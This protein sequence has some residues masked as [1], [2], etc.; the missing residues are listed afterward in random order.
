[1]NDFETRINALDL[2]LFQYVLSQSTEGDRRSLLAIQRVLR[3]GRRGSGYV[4]LEIGSFMGG[5]L[6]P[7]VADPLCRKIISID[8]RPN[9]YPDIRGKPGK[10]QITA[11][12]ML[13]ELARV[14]GA[15]V[16]KITTFEA[17]TDTLDPLSI[18]PRPDYCF[19]DGEHTDE[20]VLRDSLFCQSV[21]QGNGWILYHDAN[22]VYE[23]IL[24]FVAGLQ[25][26]GVAFRACN[27][28]DSVFLIELGDCRLSE[29]R[30]MLGLQQASGKGYLWSL[31]DN[32]Y[33]R[34]FYR[35]LNARAYRWLKART[36]SRVFGKSDASGRW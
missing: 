10:W 6:Q 13:R 16:E 29:S 3:E 21:L 31:H 8:P 34:R 25:H 33:Y 4:Y 24:A 7:H 36:W 1:M 23:G 18:K 26:A 12:T 30:L 22:L 11:E 28:E 17:G 5:S 2:T 9:L 19:V 27:F 20:A 14:P 15:D 35:L 32:D